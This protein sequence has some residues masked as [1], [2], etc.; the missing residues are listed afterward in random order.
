MGLRESLP[1]LVAVLIGL[2]NRKGGGDG[3]QDNLWGLGGEASN[4][5][6]SP[7]HTGKEWQRQQ[8]ID[9]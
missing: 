1:H 2:G 5:K 7:G 8:D 4:R 3:S 6:D 9:L